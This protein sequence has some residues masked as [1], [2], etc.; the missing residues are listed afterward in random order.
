[1]RFRRK[2]INPNIFKILGSGSGWLWIGLGW[3]GVWMTFGLASFGLVLGWVR[4]GLGLT[5]V[6]FG[7]LGVGFALA[8]VFFEFAFGWEL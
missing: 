8:F 3:I 7:L 4:L 1:M 2:G 6:R 5:W